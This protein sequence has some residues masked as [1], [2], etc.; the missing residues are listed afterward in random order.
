MNFS[1]LHCS[2]TLTHRLLL[3]I[4]YRSKSKRV[5]WPKK[6]WTQYVRNVYYAHIERT[7]RLVLNRFHYVPSQYVILDATH[8]CKPQTKTAW[9]L[10]TRWS[11]RHLDDENGLLR[12]WRKLQAYNVLLYTLK[13]MSLEFKK[14]VVN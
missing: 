5:T 1:W 6:W 11:F 4:H 12:A 7:D 14:K 9:G 2:S 8:D 3:L 10:T 13:T